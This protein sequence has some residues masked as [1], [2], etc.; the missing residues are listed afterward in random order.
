MTLLTIK[1]R[2][3][4]WIFNVRLSISEHYDV[5]KSGANSLLINPYLVSC[6]YRWL[7][8]RIVY[9]PESATGMLPLY[10]MYLWLM[11]ISL[12]SSSSLMTSLLLRSFMRKR[13]M[14]RS[15]CTKPTIGVF[16]I[17]TMITI[18]NSR[19][20]DLFLHTNNSCV[21]YYYLLSFHWEYFTNKEYFTT[22]TFKLFI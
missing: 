13:R 2:N 7:Y 22:T 20:I 10:H 18:Y 6:N 5:I 14:R 17:V 16:D 1:C 12:T 4:I 3:V 21:R 15:V 8:M 19:D 9:S 11:E